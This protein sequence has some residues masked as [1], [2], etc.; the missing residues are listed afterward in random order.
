MPDSMNF[1]NDPNAMPQQG[2]PMQGWDP[3]QY[4]VQ[5][6]DGSYQQGMYAPQDIQAQQAMY[7][8][9]MGGQMYQGYP[10]QMQQMYDPQAQYAQQNGMYYPDP[11][12][13]Q[14]YESPEAEAERM[15]QQAQMRATSMFGPK[16][17]GAQPMQDMDYNGAVMGSGMPMPGA[18]QPMQQSPQPDYGMQAQSPTQ[19]GAMPP[20]QPQQTGM[21]SLPEQQAA[22]HA[23]RP[24]AAPAPAAAPVIAGE[25]P[26]KSKAVMSLVFGVFSIIFA[27]LPPIGIVLGWLS[28]RFA[29]KY[30]QA[31]GSAAAADSGRIF[32][33]VGLIFSIIMFVVMGFALAYVAG[34]TF[35]NYGARALAIY[36]N[37][38]PLGELIGRFPLA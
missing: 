16:D 21:G 5:M 36:Y 7:G 35:G 8:N 13:G 24:Q 9:Q 19:T 30:K 34:A 33:R 32:G 31:G 20:V 11:S 25:P 2:M 18:Q 37:H 26:A 12:M 14:V 3:N 22:A 17:V 10:D 38:S 15:A 27:I 23:Q 4:G 28:T 1:A 6:P 29:K